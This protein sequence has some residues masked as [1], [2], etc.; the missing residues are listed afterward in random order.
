MHPAV[1]RRRADQ[2]LGQLQARQRQLRE[3]EAAI[4]V[5]ARDIAACR[6]ELD[7]GKVAAD[8]ACGD[9]AGLRAELRAQHDTAMEV[10]ACCPAC[11]PV[12]L[13]KLPTGRPAPEYLQRTRRPL[14]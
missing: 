7:A 9:A 3:A 13:H 12:C 11:S 8:T 5:A 2:Q 1:P 10:R 6:V 14:P 4:A